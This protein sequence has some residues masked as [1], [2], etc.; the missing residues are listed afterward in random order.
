MRIV[1][2]SNWNSDLH[3][4]GAGTYARCILQLLE[5][6]YPHAEIVRVESEAQSSGAGR[7]MRQAACLLR[8][9][10]SDHSAKWHFDYDAGVA[11]GVRRAVAQAKPHITFLIGTGAGIYRTYLPADAPFIVVVPSI[12]SRTYEEQLAR[13]PAPIRWVFRDWLGDARKHLD[14][15]RQVL[16]DAQG[17]VAVSGEQQALVLEM[18]G[19]P[20]P[21]LVVPPVFPETSVSRRAPQH[22]PIRLG[23]LGK[24]SWWPNREAID[25][26][27]TEVWPAANRDGLEL[28]LCGEGSEAFDG[29]ASGVRAYGYRKDLADFWR[30]TDIFINPMRS[31]TGVNVK[32]CEAIHHGLPVLSSPEGLRGLD[33]AGDPAVVQCDSPQAWRAQLEPGALDELRRRAPNAALRQSFDLTPA[34]PRFRTFVDSLRAQEEC[35]QAASSA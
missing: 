30:D 9:L 4:G 29:R 25:W 13:M 17:C 35:R 23:F 19:K 8:A 24:F 32:V 33:L 11:A 22:S 12:E 18:S 6:A 34:V 28:H 1:W 16:G 31:P 7:G 15:E 27:L 20:L 21:S 2:V 10:A 5:R 26:F 3:R 14:F